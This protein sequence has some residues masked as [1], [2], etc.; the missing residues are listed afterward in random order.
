MKNETCQCIV[1][2]SGACGK[3]VTHQIT[4]EGE[5]PTPVCEDC[6]DRVM[7]NDYLKYNGPG[8]YQKER[9]RY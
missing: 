7:R 1:G 3:R 9:V 5:K 4:A 8:V 6:A 2:S